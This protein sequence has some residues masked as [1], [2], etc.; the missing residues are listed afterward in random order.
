MGNRIY[1]YVVTHD[2]GYAPCV[3]NNLLS[4]CICKPK[5]RKFAEIGDWLIGFTSVAISKSLLV[6]MNSVIYIAQVTGKVSM[7][8]Y[9]LDRRE[10]RKDKIYGIENGQLV[11]LGGEIHNT[12]YHHRRDK[13]GIY[14]LKSN[15]FKY[16]GQEPEILPPELEDL[17]MSDKTKRRGERIKT[18]SYQLRELEKYANTLLSRN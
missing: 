6:D 9:F 10:V 18:T 4:L 8:E 14:C 15:K 16:F 12:E 11:H 1:R 17:N 3:D 13:R 7:E 5:I 2:H